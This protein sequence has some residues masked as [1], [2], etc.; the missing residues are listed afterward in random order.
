MSMSKSRRI[1]LLIIIFL[2]VMQVAQPKKNLA[3]GVSQNDISNV[4][5]MPVELKEMLVKKCYDCHSNNTRYPWYANVQ[6][7]GW[8]LAAHVHDGKEELNFSEF[9]TY[10]AKRVAHKMEELVEV[11]EDREMPL[12]GYTMFHAGTEVTETDERLIKEWVSS[13]NL[14]KEN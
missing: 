13:L 3:E 12:K 4:Y 10:N 1:G 8:W 2:I 11:V 9:K 6:P 7:I 5:N 14:P